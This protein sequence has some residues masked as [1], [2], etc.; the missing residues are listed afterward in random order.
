[1]T[2]AELDTTLTVENLGA[3]D[4]ATIEG[5]LERGDGIAIYRN[6]EFGHSHFGHRQFVSYG[7]R[8]AQ[9]ETDEPPKRL[10]D[11]GGRINWRY[12]LEGAF[13]A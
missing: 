1:M 9:L 2:R 6:I 12:H 8:K 5:W 7:S 10:P 11:I 13:R 4:R 3:A